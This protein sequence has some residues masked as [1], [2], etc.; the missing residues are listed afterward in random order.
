MLLAM[1]IHDKE[2]LFLVD[3]SLWIGDV[4][5]NRQNQNKNTWVAASVSAEINL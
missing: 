5:T 4:Q 3:S 2:V 1:C